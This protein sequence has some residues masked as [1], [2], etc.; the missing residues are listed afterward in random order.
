MEDSVIRVEPFKSPPNGKK[1]SENSV[2]MATKNGKKNT[3]PR[4]DTK[5]PILGTT[6]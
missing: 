2:E 1:K 3:M 4:K 6:V 5:S